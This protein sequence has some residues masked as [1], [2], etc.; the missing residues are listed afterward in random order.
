M[1]VTT[2]SRNYLIVVQAACYRMSDSTFAIE[3][4]FAEHIR[5]LKQKLDP[6]FESII[7]AAPQ[8]TEEFYS[9]NKGNLACIVEEDEQIFFAPLFPKSASFAGFWLKHAVSVWRTLWKLTEKSRIVHSGLADDIWRPALLFANIASVLRKRKM[10]FV[11]DIDFRNDAWMYYKTS[12]WSQKSYLLCRFIYD[13]LRIVQVKLAPRFCDLV[14][15]KSAKMVDDF[16]KGRSN[17]RNFFDTA[18][19]AKHIISEEKLDKKLKRLDERGQPLALV[20]FGRFV[21]YK[22]LDR[23][24]RAVHLANQR[25]PGCVT[26]TLIGAGDDKQALYDLV[27]QLGGGYVTFRE[28]LPYG[29]ELFDTLFEYDIMLATPLTED[30]PRAAFDSMASGLPVLA[31]DIVYYQDLLVSGAVELSPWPE[32]EPLADAIASLNRRRGDLVEMARQ[33]VDFARSNTQEIWLD[34]RI[35]WT[36]ELLDEADYRK[37]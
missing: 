2:V 15:L 16:G 5:I 33:A 35:D 34:R 26:F 20:F 27:L 25:D 36:I 4:A 10:I 18:H 29:P 24:I 23:A 8:L 13:P 30:T 7:I 9:A 6:H 14:L 11:V 1:T 3:S 37:N 21:K 28:P 22:G 32:V 31:F 17:V 19:S 12:T